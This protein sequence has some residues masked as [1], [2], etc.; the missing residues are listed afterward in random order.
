MVVTDLEANEQQIRYR[1][2]HHPPSDYWLRILGGSGGEFQLYL[3]CPR[4]PNTLVSRGSNCWGEFRLLI[5][6]Y[7][8]IIDLSGRCLEIYHKLI[9]HNDSQKLP[10][11]ASLGL[12]CIQ[13]GIQQIKFCH[14]SQYSATFWIDFTVQLRTS[15][16]TSNAFWNNSRFLKIE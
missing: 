13:T 15:F 14:N 12:V 16:S 4:K 6:R 3:R 5:D 1:G 7:R 2:T 11:R 8:N 10:T 9:G